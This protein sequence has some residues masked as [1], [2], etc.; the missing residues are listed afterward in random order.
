[1]MHSVR[2]QTE[3]VS[4]PVVRE[5]IEQ[6]NTTQEQIVL[7]RRELEFLRMSCM[8]AIQQRSDELN[9]VL[10]RQLETEVKQLL[11]HRQRCNDK[12]IETVCHDLE[13]RH[14][15][16]MQSIKSQH[17]R[18]V[19]AMEKRFD[20]EREELLE[21]NSKLRRQ[22]HYYQD[23]YA[24]AEGNLQSVLQRHKIKLPSKSAPPLDLFDGYAMRSQ[25][26]TARSQVDELKQTQTAT[27]RRFKSAQFTMRLNQHQL[28]EEI[29]Q[30]QKREVAL[31]Q[32]IAT[33]RSQIDDLTA[34]TADERSKSAAKIKAKLLDD[35]ALAFQRKLDEELQRAEQR[36]KQNEILMLEQHEASLMRAKVAFQ[37]QVDGI[38]A[39]HAQAVAHM[40]REHKNEI[41][42]LERNWKRKV[43]VTRQSLKTVSTPET[44]AVLADRQAQLLSLIAQRQASSLPQLKPA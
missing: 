18:Q 6:V 26:K 27:Q 16:E 36:A 2:S 9:S 19:E 13:Q 29:V 15:A 17:A 14:Q 11:L 7:L 21:L 43:V 33:L 5:F 32:E 37:Q 28:Q 35:T 42:V 25:L 20:K 31:Q 34:T 3:A 12:R 38:K 4:I 10:H 30:G 40:Q 1:M 39:S 8:S 23:A 44:L 24:Q 22:A 41:A